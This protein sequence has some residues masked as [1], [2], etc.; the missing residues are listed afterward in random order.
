MARIVTT[1]TTDWPA[2][3]A[4]AYLSDFSHAAEWDPGTVEASRL[5]VGPVRVGSEF[6]LVVVA[7]GRR[8]RLRYR[9]TDLAPGRVTFLAR[10][11]TLVSEDTV[12]VVER[13]GATEVT[14]DAGLRFR[15]LLRVADPL[16][17]PTFRHLVDEGIEGLTRR[18]SSDP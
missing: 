18:L 5:D 4:F 9:I 2:A 7:G 17:A 11:A 13:D 1:V 3:Q 12:T 6:D 16:L 14:Y 15:G 8:L 10:T